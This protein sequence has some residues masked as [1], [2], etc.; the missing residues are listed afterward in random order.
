MKT[1]CFGFLFVLTAC[2]QTIVSPTR[3]AVASE[4]IPPSPT[5]A[6]SPSPTL[7]LLPPPTGTPVPRWVDYQS[8]LASAIHPKETG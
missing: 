3:Q 6:A 5:V 8:A 1:V 7:A 2:S 4:T